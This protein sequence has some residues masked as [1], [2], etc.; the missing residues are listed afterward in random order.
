MDFDLAELQEAEY[1]GSA[2]SCLSTQQVLSKTGV[3]PSAINKLTNNKA[4][5]S[6]GL[7]NESVALLQEENRRLKK[8]L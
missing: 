1:L 2:G 7:G 6:A 3:K 4:G 5:N 8:L